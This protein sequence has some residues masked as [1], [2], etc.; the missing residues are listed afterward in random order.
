MIHEKLYI[1][2]TLEKIQAPFGVATLKRMVIPTESNSSQR[3]FC[4]VSSVSPC[5]KHVGN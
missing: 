5:E 4:S 2:L 3:R 1:T